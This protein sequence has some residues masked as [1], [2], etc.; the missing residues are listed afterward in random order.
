MN[1]EVFGVLALIF[2][3]VILAGVAMII[4]GEW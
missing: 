2:S 1:I 3:P 4:A